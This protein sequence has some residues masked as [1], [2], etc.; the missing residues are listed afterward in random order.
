MLPYA[1]AAAARLKR[2][3]S[4]L[5]MH[6]LY[7]DVLV[8]AG[9]LRPASILARAI[10]CAN[11]LMFRALD[12]VDH[13]RARHRT[14]AVALR[15]RDV[16]QDPVHS[17]LGDAGAG[18]PADRPDNPYRRLHAARFVVGLSGN[19]GFTHDPDVVFEAARLLRDD[20]G[21]SFPALGLGR[22]LRTTE[23]NAVRCRSAQR[24]AGRARAEDETSNSFLPP[25]MSGS[26][27]IAST[28]PACRCR[29]GSTI[30]WRSAGRC[31]LRFG[32][33]C[34]GG[35]DCQ[36]AWPRLGGRARRPGRTAR[37][38]YAWHRRPK[39]HRRAERA[40]TIAQRYN[41]AAAMAGYADLMQKLLRER[42]MIVTN[43]RR[44]KRHISAPWQ[45]RR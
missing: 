40:A 9:L 30:C 42:R 22:R 17:E 1:V 39:I 16:R 23:A 20:A 4:A 24:D 6:D 5:I 26:F 27:P 11:A 31:I 10:R 43:A 14:A 35:A 19:L 25:R 13:H 18:G 3:R 45:C 36:R 28:L 41:F 7:P 21:N 15:G 8:M 33:Q 32:S 2:A 37:E 12:A 34:R 29:A 38:R 44:A